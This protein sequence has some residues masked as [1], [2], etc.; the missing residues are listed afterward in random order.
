MKSMTH[1][2]YSGN[3]EF[4]YEDKVFHGS[5]LDIND[6]VTY[7]GSTVAEL[8]NAFKEAVEDYLS[9][10]KE[11]GKSPEKPF[12]GLF[13]VRVTPSL[14]RKI[15]VNAKRKGVTQ[16]TYINKIL[17]DSVEQDSAL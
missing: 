1:K 6:L 10:C 2:G 7:E 15:A 13:Q 3:A 11:I 9:L 14:H 16:N 4:S 5:I 8:E 17:K 12:K